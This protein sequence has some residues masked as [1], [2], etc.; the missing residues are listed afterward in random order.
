[1][2]AFTFGAKA[3]FKC[4]IPSIAMLRPQFLKVVDKW[5]GDFLFKAIFDEYALF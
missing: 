1:M 3:A 4:G 5:V 2:S